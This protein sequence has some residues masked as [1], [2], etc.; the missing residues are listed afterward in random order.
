MLPSLTSLLCGQKV[1]LITISP[2]SLVIVILAV[3]RVTHLLWGEDGPWDLVVRLRR[4]AGN[5]VV[6]SALDCFYCLSLWIAA[7]MAWLMGHRW[8]ERILLWLAFSAGAI[9]LER[10][11]AEQTESEKGHSIPM[12]SSAESQSRPNASPQAI[13]HE[14]PLS[15]NPRKEA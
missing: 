4:L 2:I 13:W 15:A 6:G 9:L 12:W 5:S 11:S 8:Q 7:P 3:W 10:V 1:M 14:E